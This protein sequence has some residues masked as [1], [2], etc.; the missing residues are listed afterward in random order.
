MSGYAFHPDAVAD[1]DEIWEYIA[2]DNVDAADRVLAD[3]HS[4]LTMRLRHRR[5]EPGLFRVTAWLVRARRTEH[6]RSTHGRLKWGVVYD[7]PQRR[8]QF[9]RIFLHT[10]DRAGTAGQPSE[11]PADAS[12]ARKNPC[13]DSER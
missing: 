10:F 11:G 8:V 12:N 6:R 5:I 3:I 7:Q 1:L 4:T 13:I 2:R 9:A